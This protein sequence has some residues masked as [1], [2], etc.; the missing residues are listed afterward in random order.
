MFWGE[1]LDRKEKESSIGK[2]T[3]LEASMYPLGQKINVAWRIRFPFYA[4]YY[5][6]STSTSG[7]ARPCTPTISGPLPLLVMFF[8][9]P[10]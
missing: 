6:A 5:K 7:Y 8:F 10:S 1:I 2:N 4:H 3:L 9:L